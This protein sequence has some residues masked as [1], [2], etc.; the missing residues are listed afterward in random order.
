MQGPA[1]LCT[2]DGGVFSCRLLLSLVKQPLTKSRTF[3]EKS[4]TGREGQSPRR[5]R[6]RQPL[7]M[8]P[9]KEEKV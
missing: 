2:A 5:R 6:R 9:A 4:L 3:P 1:H 8:R 7:P